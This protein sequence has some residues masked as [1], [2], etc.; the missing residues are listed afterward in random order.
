MKRIISSAFLCIVFLTMMLSGCRWDKLLSTYKYSTESKNFIQPAAVDGWVKKDAITTSTNDG[1]F[2]CFTNDTEKADDFISTQRTLL[3]FLRDCGAKIDKME[4]YGTDYGY[5]F[6]ES[7]D[8][9]VYVALS[10]MRSWQQVLITLQTIW[11]DYTEYGYVYAMANAIA[12]ELG[13]RIDPA[14]SVSIASLDTFFI[15]NPDVINLLY[16]TFTTKLASEETVNNS[17]ALAIHLFKNIQWREAIAKSVKDQLDDYYSLVSTY[18]QDISVPFN[19]QTCGYAYYGDN[20]KL[21]IMTTYAEL[22]IDGNYRDTVESLFGDYWTTYSSIYVTANTIN[23]E[24]TTAVKNFGLEDKA[25]R[26]K[27]IWLDSEKDST[28]NYIGSGTDGVYY[29]ST[30]IAYI[31]SIRPYLHEYHHHIEYLLTNRN[32]STW[33][34]QAFCEIGSSHSYYKQLVVENTFGRNEEGSKLFYSFTGRTFQSGQDDFFEAWDILCYINDYYQLSYLTGAQSQN[35]FSRYLIDLY[36]EKE[37]YNLMLFPDT[38]EETT[39]KTWEQLASE[40]E[41][42]IRSKYEGIQTPR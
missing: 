39:G 18:A 13:W 23:E 15:E 21:R 33:Q 17:K 3:R 38:I 36:G 22:I 7:S 30:H 6:S 2:Y 9:A 40:W 19:R 20:V 16:P 5:S 27:I 37:V 10:D 42:H 34:S 41:K 24:I 29:S 25:G 35:S 14:P 31:T 26:I 1:I 4:Y 28:K 11:G 32:A 8:K 12:E